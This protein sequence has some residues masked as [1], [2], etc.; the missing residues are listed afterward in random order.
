MVV[1]SPHLH[2]RSRVR[3]GPPFPPV[4]WGSSVTGQPKG[5]G[6]SAGLRSLH[7]LNIRGLIT[8]EQSK[9]PF[10]HDILHNPATNSSFA[11]GITES[12]LRDHT[13][14]EIDIPD[15]KPYRADRKRLKAKRG[16]ESGGAVLY[17][18]NDYA[19]DPTFEFVSGNNECIGVFIESANTMVYV[20][21]RQPDSKNH[22]STSKE[23]AELTNAL[24]AHMTSLPTPT[25]NIILMGDFNLPNA[26]WETGETLL[27]A[28]SDS[29]P[30][31][32]R[33]MI[34]LLYDLSLNHFLVQQVDGPTHIKGNTL[35]LMFTNN[36]D[37]LHEYTSS[38]CASE[39]SDHHHMEFVLSLDSPSTEVEEPEDPEPLD[40]AREWRQ[41]NFFSEDVNWAALSDDL[42]NQDWADAI[43]ST[44][45][46]QLHET[47][48]ARCLAIAKA[49][50][51]LRKAQGPRQ[52]IPPHRRRLMRRRTRLRR[53]QD[54][55]AHQSAAASK[56]LTNIERELRTS[57]ANQ[58]EFEEN[59]AV[60]NIKTNP[61]FFFSYAKKYSKTKTGI[62]PLRTADRSLTS[63]PKKMAELLS[64]QYKSAFSQPHFADS[65]PESVFPDDDP[66][67]QSNTISDIPW[68]EKDF[69][70]AM[71]ELRCN[72]AAGPDGIPAILLKKCANALAPALLLLWKKCFHAGITPSA[73]KSATIIPI[74]KGKSKAVPKNYRPVA[75]TSQIC[76]VFEKVVRKHLVQF[77]D[78][79]QLFNPSQHG[80]RANRSCLSQLLTHFDRITANL[81]DGNGVDVVY[82]DFA[83]AFDKVDIGITLRKLHALGVRGALGRW[84]I[85]FL[86]GRTQSVVVNNIK[87]APTEVVSGVP[88]GSVLGP[89][90]FLI[91]LGDI[92]SGVVSSFVSSFADDTRVGIPIKSSADAAL[93]Q[94]DLNHIYKWSIT[95]NMQ[96]NSDKFEMLRY[97]AN[98][99]QPRPPQTLLSD[100]GSPIEIKTS[101]RDLG[102]T[103][104]DDAKFTK[105][106]QERVSVA[107][108]L[109][110]WA[111]RVFR[112]R[113]LPAMMTIWKSLILCHLDYCSQLWSPSKTGEIQL[114]EATQ[115]AFLKKIPQ[116][117]G[118][119]YWEQLKFCKLFSLE[120]RRERYSII[121]TW[122]I[123][124]GQVPNLESTPITARSH[125][126][127]GRE[128]FIPRVSNTSPSSIQALRASSFA[129]R[130]PR[131]FNTLPLSIR[132]LTNCKPEIFKAALDAYLCSIPDEPLIPGL[133]QFRR[134]DS[135]SLIDWAAAR[136][137]NINGAGPTG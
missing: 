111:L 3:F 64:D 1:E 79:N 101:L 96:F 126:R 74:H 21:Y 89:L 102:V 92:D 11:F 108:K 118:M 72:A 4:A 44:D 58:R 110:G 133:T 23:F 42:A 131:L 28:D 70:D 65:A 37:S 53:K 24:D 31:E 27:D 16:R 5:D 39:I 25:P 87:S 116:L 60:G 137:A 40:A 13:D 46:T 112:T 50:V 52:K 59:K 78:V 66:A 83:K 32:K 12:W 38:Q 119:S 122:R 14:A 136:D 94:Q 91:L 90:I 35:D 109:I 106:I 33:R 67:Q 115:R 30:A 57:Y 41:L 80:F 129:I 10:I 132:N 128:C 98:P 107:N 86:L 68:V 88:Q 69:E 125:I 130:G 26:D 48:S 20:A 123:I 73:C 77:L 97:N 8:K 99:A 93:L 61:K 100:D 81:D 75:L 85:S 49:H 76:K 17:V 105:H 43:N 9:V 22:R 113:A 45:A 36:S 71:K 117:G 82:L 34:K 29:I 55:S 135:N 51:P 95:A 134:A 62:G 104:T 120:R 84:L 47:F 54:E 124:E 18:H 15:F 103:M 7:L 127:R 2:R 63:S 121:Y 114:L 56:C 6:H 19:S